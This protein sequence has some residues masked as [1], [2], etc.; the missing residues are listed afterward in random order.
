MTGVQTCALPIYGVAV[1]AWHVV[2]GLNDVPGM[3]CNAVTGAMYAF[4]S[5][6]LPPGVTDAQYCLALL[7]ETGICLVP[8]SGFG[9]A[10][11]TWHFRATILPP[12]E[13]IE[14]VVQRIGE[15]HERFVSAR[16]TLSEN[17]PVPRP[18]PRGRKPAPV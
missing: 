7:E 18:A 14:R 12:I 6:E 9:Q 1:H 10:A 13:Q 2:E 5:L 4:P 8:G 11:E 17:D 15:F 16:S 3:H